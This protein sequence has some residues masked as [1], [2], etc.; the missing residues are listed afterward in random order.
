[1]INWKPFNR[2]KMPREEVAVIVYAPKDEYGD[3]VL[4][5]DVWYY[6]KEFRRWRFASVKT[7]MVK[8][9]C[10]AIEFPFPPMSSCPQ[11]TR[12]RWARRGTILRRRGA[13]FPLLRR[14]QCLK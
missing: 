2:A 8:N 14:S 1:M 10:L 13:V 12:C 11:P 4:T 9:Y 5:N 7:A 3:E 6:S